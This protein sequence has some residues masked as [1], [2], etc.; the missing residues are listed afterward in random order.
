MQQDDD[1]ISCERS[2]EPSCP[3][4]ILSDHE[5]DER[6]KGQ[7]QHEAVE[8]GEQRACNI[9]SNGDIDDDNIQDNDKCEGVRPA[10]QCQPSPSCDS[11]IKSSCKQRLQNFDKGVSTMQSTQHLH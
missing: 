2:E 3:T 8:H 1:C 6:E 4:L 10:K 9:S 11:V 5:D 7:Q